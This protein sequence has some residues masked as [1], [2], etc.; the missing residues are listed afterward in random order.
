MKGRAGGHVD[1]REGEQS[2]NEKKKKRKTN[3][4][5]PR[6]RE[7]KK[8]AAGA[9]KKWGTTPLAFASERGVPCNLLREEE[10]QREREKKRREKKERY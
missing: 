6:I 9:G 4:H 8:G 1:G 7:R 3:R 2:T 10:H 5:A